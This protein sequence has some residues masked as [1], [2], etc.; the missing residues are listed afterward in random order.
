MKMRK[1]IWEKEKKQ[2]EDGDE[3]LMNL[4]L[5]TLSDALGNPDDVADLLLT[6]LEV[7]VENTVAHLRLKGQLVQL[8]LVLKERVLERFVAGRGA[9][10]KVCK[11]T[12]VLRQVA[13]ALTDLVDVSSLCQTGCA[14]GVQRPKVGE[15]LGAVIHRQ[16]CAKRVDCD[17]DRPPVCFKLF[18]GKR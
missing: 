13:H 3:T 4:S 5:L 16:L 9:A 8:N 10:A 1:R 14:C 12:A 15:Q 2:L 6:E 18:K 11:Q 7:G 17:G